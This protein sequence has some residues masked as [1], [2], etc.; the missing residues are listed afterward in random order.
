MS[1]GYFG[2]TWYNPLNILTV[3][4]VRIRMER[5]V[6]GVFIREVSSVSGRQK[7]YNLYRRRD[8]TLEFD[9]FKST[10]EVEDFIRHFNSNP[11]NATTYRVV[12]PPVGSF[13]P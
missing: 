4:G 8:L 6:V 3:P 5:R 7:R 10:K 1:L 9:G 12:S 11:R 2:F 13:V